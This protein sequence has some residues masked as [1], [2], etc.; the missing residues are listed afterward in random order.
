MYLIP[1]GLK[2]AASATDAAIH[3]K[4][5]GPSLPLDLAW[6]VITLIILIEETNCIMEIVQSLKESDL[7]INCVVKQLKME[8]NNIKGRFFG[9]SLGTF[10]VF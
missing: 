1:L 2:A 7:L 8:Q 5:F 9:M 6:G 10:R 4:I 3:K